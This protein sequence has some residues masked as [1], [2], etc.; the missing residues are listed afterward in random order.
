MSFVRPFL[1]GLLLALVLVLVALVAEGYH[2]EQLF[3]LSLLP[4]LALHGAAVFTPIAG[5]LR[6]LVRG[7]L[8]FA[9]S[10]AVGYTT[11]LY[12]HERTDWFRDMSGWI[13]VIV[14]L[15]AAIPGGTAAAAESPRR[16]LA[17]ASGFTFSLCMAAKLGGA[18]HPGYM[19]LLVV[20]TFVGVIVNALDRGHPRSR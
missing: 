17:L 15:H 12:L 2:D 18:A 7:A 11:Y 10:A 6:R 8:G 14:M 19:I 1:L 3:W 9:A 20:G 4:L 13:I 5:C 16:G